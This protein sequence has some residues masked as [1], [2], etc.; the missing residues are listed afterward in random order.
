MCYLDVTHY[1]SSDEAIPHGHLRVAQAV[2]Q[3]AKPHN[4]AMQ[5]AHHMRILGCIYSLGVCELDIEVLIDR[6]QFPGDS[7]VILQL[8][9]HLLPNQGLKI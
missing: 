6:V 1:A 3:H 2:V 4:P 7:E 9:G 8:H 5:T